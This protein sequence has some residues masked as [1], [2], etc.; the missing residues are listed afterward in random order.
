[1]RAS[2]TDPCGRHP[3]PRYIMEMIAYCKAKGTT[4]SA[5]HRSVTPGE[6][7]SAGSA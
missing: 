5:H 4:C 6:A 1:M 3:H 7:V 2:R